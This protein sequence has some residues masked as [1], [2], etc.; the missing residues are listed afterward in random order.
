MSVWI[1]GLPLLLVIP[2]VVRLLRRQPSV[3]LRR[4]AI[5]NILITL[6]AAVLLA[7]AARAEAAPTAQ[8]VTD[9]AASAAGD[10]YIAAAIAVAGS[11][12]GAG[13]AVAYTGAAAVA[14]ISEKPE[15]MGRSIVFV[16]LAEGI[17]IY[18]LIIGVLILNR[19]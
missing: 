7:L 13:I 5:G 1:I 10:A 11:A 9:A 6:A 14:A 16:G 19:V 3:W 2:V 8:A 4:V 12:V 17:A 18:G 15:L